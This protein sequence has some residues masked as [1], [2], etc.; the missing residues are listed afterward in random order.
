M[1][2][3]SEFYIPPLP[4]AALFLEKRL[5]SKRLKL[6]NERFNEV[7]QGEK[8]HF[9]RVQFSNKVVIIN[10]NSNQDTSA[11]NIDQ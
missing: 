5:E 2:D 9:D 7:Y 3:I 10:D 1:T 11:A 6:A 8:E 4:H